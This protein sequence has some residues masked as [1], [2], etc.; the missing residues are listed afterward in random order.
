[1]TYVKILFMDPQ[2]LPTQKSYSGRRS[3]PTPRDPGDIR[4]TDVVGA[5]FLA[6]AFFLIAAAICATW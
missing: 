3:R 2:T 5:F 4:P 6:G 1:M